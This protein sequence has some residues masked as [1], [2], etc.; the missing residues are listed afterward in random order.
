MN[1]QLSRLIRVCLSRQHLL[2]SLQSDEKNSGDGVKNPFFL[3]EEGEKALR[4]VLITAAKRRYP[5]KNIY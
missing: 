3:E 2:N 1:R 4:C 5:F